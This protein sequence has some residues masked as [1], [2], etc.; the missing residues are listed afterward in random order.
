MNIAKHIVEQQS[1]LLRAI[2]KASNAFRSLPECHSSLDLS[3]TAPGT[4]EA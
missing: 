2:L 1:Y 3:K 4:P